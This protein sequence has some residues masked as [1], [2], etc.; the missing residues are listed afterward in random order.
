MEVEILNT[1]QKYYILVNSASFLFPLFFPP[2]QLSYAT[3]A[4]RH[5]EKTLNF[6][7]HLFFIFIPIKHYFLI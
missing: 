1:P 5:A 2:I 6:S 4:Q 3:D 7:M